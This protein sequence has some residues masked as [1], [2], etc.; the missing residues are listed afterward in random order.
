MDSMEG[1]EMAHATLR[2]CSGGQP[3]YRVKVHYD[4]QGVCYFHDGLSKF[5]IDYGVHEGWFLLLIRHDGKKNFTVC[6]FYGTLSAVPS[7]PG[8]HDQA[9][10]TSSAGFSGMKSMQRSHRVEEGEHLPG[11]EHFILL[12]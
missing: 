10:S 9:S 7:P 5:F 3:K 8:R 1:Q 11:E 6:I 12:E 2:E 4:G